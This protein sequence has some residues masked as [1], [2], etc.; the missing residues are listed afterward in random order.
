MASLTRC[1]RYPPTETGTEDEV[2]SVHPTA[3]ASTRAP[4]QELDPEPAATV[5]W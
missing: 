1:A 3:V 4:V 2:G 5:A